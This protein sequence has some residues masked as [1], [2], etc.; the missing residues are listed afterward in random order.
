MISDA[1]MRKGLQDIQNELDNLSKQYWPSVEELM[2][3]VWEVFKKATVADEPSVPPAYVREE[4]KGAEPAPYFIEVDQQG[5]SK[6]NAGR[7]WNVVGPDGVALST[8]YMEEEDAQDLADDLNDAFGKGVGAVTPVGVCY[9][10]PILARTEKRVQL[11]LIEEWLQKASQ[12]IG[13]PMELDELP[14]TIGAII[15]LAHEYGW[16]GVENSKILVEFLR[17]ELEKRTEKEVE[18]NPI[19]TA[20][21]TLTR[22]FTFDQEFRQV[23]IDQVSCALMDS[24]YDIFNEKEIRDNLSMLILQRLF[25]EEEGKKPESNADHMSDLKRLWTMLEESNAATMST[26]LYKEKGDKRPYRLM[27]LVEGEEEVEEINDA[28]EAIQKDWHKG[29]EI[30]FD[31]KGEGE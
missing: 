12:H 21:V 20:R 11:V 19:H 2:K 13:P 22:R 28:L 10:V 18:D 30:R 24:G 6:C 15:S 26:K 31:M 9:G 1:M 17:A 5:C 23:Y 27:L 25:D 8:S 14:D 29:E 4:D 3:K 7:S 16:N